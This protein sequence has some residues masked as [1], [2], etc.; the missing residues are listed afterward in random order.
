MSF[1][2]FFFLFIAAEDTYPQQEQ[3]ELVLT[4]NED[5]GYNIHVGEVSF[6]QV[7]TFTQVNFQHLF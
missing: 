1:V 2:N 5:F 6:V 4:T 3:K 7:I